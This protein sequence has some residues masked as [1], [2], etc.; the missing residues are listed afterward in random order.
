MSATVRNRPAAAEVERLVCLADDDWDAVVA[1]AG[2]PYRFSHRAAAGRALEAAYPSHSFTPYRVDYRDGA[3]I[4]YPLVRIDRPIQSLSKIVGMPLGLE[5]T[6][7]ALAGELQQA[8]LEGLSRA[9]DFKGSLHIHGGAGGSPPPIGRVTSLVTHL[10]DL[11]GGFDAVWSGAFDAK[12]RNMCRKAE[13]AGV[14]VAEET[15]PAAMAAYFELYA[16]SARSWGYSEPPYPRRLFDA[17][18]G[19]GA[20]ELWLARLDGALIAGAMFLRGSEDLLYWSAAVDRE[21]RGAAPSNA[22]LH[23]AICSACERGI[24]YLD[25]G[26]STGLPGVEAFKRSFGAQPRDYRTVN[27]ASTRQ[28]RLRRWE[29]RLRS[30]RGV[31]R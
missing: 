13:R 14:R 31:R 21:H 16:N 12:T 19:S 8:H 25:F 22:V 24:A 17:L 6:P 30:R 5:G 15:T 7:I 18:L 4:L 20:A 11:R 28:R 1:A 23:A 29:N 27:T 2:R 3:Q 9:L 26:A 10:L